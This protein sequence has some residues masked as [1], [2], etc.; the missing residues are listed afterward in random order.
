M[1]PSRKE[2][3]YVVL[4]TSKIPIH[5]HG[6]H[7]NDFSHIN[8]PWKA[9]KAFPCRDNTDMRVHD[10]CAQHS[11]RSPSHR[12]VSLACM[13]ASTPG[14]LPHYSMRDQKKLLPSCSHTNK[15]SIPKREQ[16]ACLI[17]GASLERNHRGMMF[18][19]A[20]VRVAPFWN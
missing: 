6:E 14:L 12:C 8:S 5:R 9:S 15:E 10:A 7:C 20:R 1:K 3:L 4:G 16:T 18:I 19:L 13:K 11:V 17:N 2:P